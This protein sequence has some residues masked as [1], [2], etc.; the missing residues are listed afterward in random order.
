MSDLK[1][2]WQEQDSFIEKLMN[3]FPDLFPT[4]AEGKVTYPSCASGIPSGWNQIVYD[5]CG[6][7]NNRRKNSY[8]CVRRQDLKS[9][10]LFLRDKIAR[11]IFVTYA[12]KILDP[13]RPFRPKNQVSFLI[14]KNTQD[15]VA[16]SWRFKLQ[17]K[18]SKFNR[19]YFNYRGYDNVYPPKI[20]I[21]Q[22]K[23]KFGTL[24]FYFDGGD[25]RDGAVVSYVEYLSSKTC[26]E[27]GDSGSLCKKRGCYA[28]LS[29]DKAKELD[30]TKCNES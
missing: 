3:D 8:R 17:S 10:I 13:Y 2:K 30:Y 14:L 15:K 4:D 20:T 9:R 22:I 19:K 16:S 7:L 12:N 27:T 1:N 21:A 18:L 28:T 29:I 26:Q 24:R 23:E 25:D 11:K 5:L 6:Y